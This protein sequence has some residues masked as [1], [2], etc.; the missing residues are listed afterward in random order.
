MDLNEEERKNNGKV[1]VCNHL[2]EYMI[3]DKLKL[4]YVFYFSKSGGFVREVKHENAK[5]WIGV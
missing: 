4:Q 1:K 5:C 2:Q 3:S